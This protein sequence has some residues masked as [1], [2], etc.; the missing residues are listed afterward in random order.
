MMLL[1][2]GIMYSQCY[3]PGSA[4]YTGTFDLTQNPGGNYYINSGTGFLP[5]VPAGF[6]LWITGTADY[7][8]DTN[9]F[10]AGSVEVCNGGI[11]RSS[12][13]MFTTSV[14]LNRLTTGRGGVLNV[15]ITGPTNLNS[16][17]LGDIRESAVVSFCINGPVNMFSNY[18]INY[19]GSPTGKSWIVRINTPFGPL[20]ASQRLVSNSPN[21]LYVDYGIYSDP[22]ARPSTPSLP[23]GHPDNPFSDNGNCDVAGVKTDLIN[24]IDPPSTGTICTKPGATT[25]PPLT[26]KKF[27]VSTLNV[28]G[29]D[30]RLNSVIGSFYLE[31]NSKGLV[32]PRTITT[33]VISPVKGTLIYDTANK[34]LSL[35]DGSS[36]GCIVQTC[37]DN[38]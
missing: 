9:T 21:V 31:S 8:F 34:C 1:S 6:K 38:R 32:L 27:A 33:N 28:S 26:I 4:P 30:E 25:G 37:I 10:P 2:F 23:E 13:A 22:A 18:W 12:T 29:I 17:F 7:S 16:F 24:Y 14:N 15:S 20:N 19:V 3:P 36:W 5:N 35:Y 11:L